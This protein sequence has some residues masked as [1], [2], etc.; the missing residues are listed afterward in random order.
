MMKGSDYN[1]QG[2]KVPRLAVRLVGVLLFNRTGWRNRGL[3]S[4][5][6]K[7]RR[8]LFV[9][10]RIF[11]Y[12]FWVIVICF[13]GILYLICFGLIVLAVTYSFEY[14]VIVFLY[15]LVSFNSFIYCISKRR[16]VI[17][18]ELLWFVFVRFVDDVLSG[19]LRHRI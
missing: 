17:V 1:R 15:P 10:V 2:T 8:R 9:F 11:Q 14:S 13:I 18:Y 3:P 19:R 6:R 12:I 7:F 4:C 5:R 16:T